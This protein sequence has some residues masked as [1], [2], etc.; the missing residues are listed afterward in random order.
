MKNSISN[1]NELMNFRFDY[2]QFSVSIISIVIICFLMC[3]P[4]FGQEESSYIELSTGN[5]SI[6][7]N[8]KKSTILDFP[9]YLVL[10]FEQLPSSKHLK[11]EFDIT[12]EYLIATNTIISKVTKQ[13]Q[14]DRLSIEGLSWYGE[15]PSDLKLVNEKGINKKRGEVILLEFYPSISATKINEI[16]KANSV[17]RLLPKSDSKE[18]LIYRSQLTDRIASY[19][20]IHSIMNVGSG[21]FIENG[22]FYC[23]GSKTEHGYSS[24]LQY[25]K[26]NNISNLPVLGLP[27]TNLISCGRTSSNHNLSFSF[28]VPTAE[29]LGLTEWDEIRAALQEWEEVLGV[30]FN[31]D[32]NTGDIHFSFETAAFF[33]A[34]NNGGVANAIAVSYG[35]NQQTGGSLAGDIIMNELFNWNRV[36]LFNV[37]L[38]E[39]GHSLGLDHNHEDPSSTL[40][41]FYTM[42]QNVRE[43]I[44][45]D[46]IQGAN[47]LYEGTN[48]C[49][50]KLISNDFEVC[51]ENA[52]SERFVGDFNGDGRDDFIFYNTA[53]IKFAISNGSDFDVTTQTTNTF[54]QAGGWGVNNLRMLGDI[55]GDGDDDIVGFANSAI[56]V[57]KY[58][59][60]NFSFT[61][62]TTNSFT[63]A[64]GWDGDNPI[65][66]MDANGDG[67]DDIAGFGNAGLFYAYSDGIDFE[68]SFIEIEC[69]GNSHFWANRYS[70]TVRT[71]GDFNGD[72]ADD[73]LAIGEVGVYLHT[74][75]VGTANICAQAINLGVTAACS[76][77]IANNNNLTPSN[78]LPFSCVN[79]SNA[80]AWFTVEIPSTGRVTIET[81]PT[82]LSE[83]NLQDLVMEIYAGS[84]SSLTSISCNDDGGTGN[85]S[86]ITLT[87]RV[88]GEIL[89]VRVA[90]FSANQTGNFGICAYDNNILALIGCPQEYTSSNGNRIVGNLSVDRNYETN[91][92]IE[93][94]QFIGPNLNVNYEAGV[95]IS[96]LQDFE[97]TEGTTFH[98]FIG[99]CGNL[100]QEDTESNYIAN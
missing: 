80:D 68:P 20:E 16:L 15:L 34:I 52:P 6:K 91:G 2:S 49:P 19:N 58:N 21:D 73:I 84:C 5:I 32:S 60:S 72:G 59:G 26:K 45:I 47:I 12:P 11:M 30:H 67:R 8:H 69:F 18:V 57:G 70:E 96:L 94:T 41:P 83:S 63:Q 56:V 89:F 44:S 1:S 71:F 7:E 51:I 14:L 66:L 64:G 77:V 10:H 53:D 28:G 9:K 99:E 100:L 43:P 75:I 90:A 54:T 29:I 27:W 74:N 93:S 39:I 95:Q 87:N 81:T 55:D 82:T 46:V 4:S 98:A 97:V 25:R 78:N 86:K 3:N 61:S 42:G 50:E 65:V 37:M 62:Q 76:P 85:H 31:E 23:R 88:A 13:S 48:L 38:H 36:D 92:K 79:P 17:K 22:F 40:A 35:T 33:A 24:N